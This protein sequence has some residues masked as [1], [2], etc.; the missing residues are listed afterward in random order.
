MPQTRN[1]TV[2]DPLKLIIRFTIPL[3]IGN[4]FLQFA[5]M[6]EGSIVGR[7]LGVNG[8][9]AIGATTGI[10][11]V[12]RNFAQGLSIGLPVV[13]AQRFGAGDAL[14]VKK[15]VATGI[16][17]SILGWAV[18]AGALLP[19]WGAI[20]RWMK[21]PAE[22]LHDSWLYLFL[23]TAGMVVTLLHYLFFNVVRSVGDSRTPLYFQMLTGGLDI[24]L[25]WLFVAKL[26]LGV[27]GVPVAQISAQALGSVCFLWYVLKVKKNPVL[28]LTREDWRISREDFFEHFKAGTASGLMFS[29]APCGGVIIQPS[30]NSFGPEIVAGYTA[31]SQITGVFGQIYAAM[32]QAMATYVAQNYGAGLIHRVR[33]GV[34]KTIILGSALSLILTAVA[35][36]G[37]DFM[38]TLYMGD[39]TPELLGY[40]KTNMIFITMG[41]ILLV[42]ILVYRQALQALN[43][44]VL[45]IFASAM[46]LVMRSIAVIFLIPR[47]GY[48]AL[49]F[50]LFMAW[51]GTASPL[52][53][54]YFPL[55]RRLEAQNPQGDPAPEAE[56]MEEASEC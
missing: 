56:T 28:R 36:L 5:T 45:P 55:M 43:S 53:L 3:M 33:A 23:I 14:G 32:G 9:A 54:G 41:W 27:A 22:V 18:F 38:V 49:C 7:S 12:L 4:V 13:T 2:G 11:N 8:V 35:I 17:M 15:S 37:S 30:L 52:V 46:E 47:F 42:L 51:I 25:A 29:V 6:M 48:P 39:A 24:F 31:A 20:L 21:T 34:R 16:L 26:G 50:S 19:S 40:A 1:M 10:F 44:R